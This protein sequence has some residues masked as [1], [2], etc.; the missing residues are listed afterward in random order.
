LA[1]R[2]NGLSIYRKVTESGFTIIEFETARRS[3]HHQNHMS[4]ARRRDVGFISQE[5]KVQERNST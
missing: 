4:G 2:L 1:I 5:C 3:S